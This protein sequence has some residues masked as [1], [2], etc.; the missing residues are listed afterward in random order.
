M[1]RLG[2]L[3]V[4]LLLACRAGHAQ[5][6]PEPPPVSFFPQPLSKAALPINAS[7]GKSAQAAQGAR[8]RG[9]SLATREELSAVIEKRLAA[10]EKE[11]SVS[12]ERSSALI[13]DLTSL[14]AAYQEIGDYDSATA[15]LQDAIGIARIN[16]GLHSLDQADAVE[17]LM[18][19]EQAKGEHEEAERQ[20]DYLRDLARRNSDDARTVGILNKLAASEMDLARR[21]LGMAA[22]PVLMVRSTGL[23]TRPLSPTSPSLFA[24]DRPLAPQSP[25]LEALYAARSDYTAA[26]EAAD[27]THGNA[28]D[29]FAIHDALVDTVYFEHAHADMHGPDS[30]YTRSIG[31]KRL[32]TAISTAGTQIMEERLGASVRL[33]RAPV[34]IAQEMLEIGDWDLVYN[35]FGLALDRYQDAHELLV[36]RGIPGE[37]IDGMLSPEVPPVLPVRGATAVRGDDRPYRG[38]IDASVG[39]TRFGIVKRVDIT[40]Q[41]AGTSKAIEKS[42]RHWLAG[43]RFR[44]RFVNGALARSDTFDARFYFDY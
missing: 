7:G 9:E 34:E 26:I 17:S 3:F 23:V 31:A 43:S 16:Y 2:V 6:S 33:G 37:T 36:A 8:G 12:G 30:L 28:Q 39:I 32:N 5:S 24:I 4:S 14:A 35:K 11:Q 42:L 40:D 44:P 15:A 20:R 27:R 22:A 1:A 25:S 41:S 38:Y 10:L 19:A 21:S 18:A 13:G 29:L